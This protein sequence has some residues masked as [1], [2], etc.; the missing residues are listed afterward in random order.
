MSLL[1]FLDILI[2]F[3]KLVLADSSQCVRKALVQ[4]HV[5][6]VSHLGPLIVP[7]CVILRPPNYT[8]PFFDDS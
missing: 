2:P 1:R 6:T 8:S 7:N 3:C 4:V 5:T